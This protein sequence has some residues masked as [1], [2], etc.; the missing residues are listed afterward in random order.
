M[1]QNAQEVALRELERVAQPVVDAAQSF[2]K[3]QRLLLALGWDLDSVT[4]LPIA[5]IDAALNEV[6]EAVDVVLGLVPAADVGG[7]GI[8][9]LP[10]V[11][12]ALEQTA[13]AVQAVDSLVTSLDGAG[14][15]KPQGLDELPADLVDYL[16]C[17]FLQEY[18]ATLYALGALLTLVTP[19]EE[20]APPPSV[21]DTASGNVVRYPIPRPRLRLDHAPR[22]LADPLATLKAEYLQP[23]GLATTAG[24]DYTADKLFPRVAALLQTLGIAAVYGPKS[25]YRP[26]YGS[27]GNAVVERTLGVLSTIEVPAGLVQMGA[28]FALSPAD[29]GGL[30]LVVRPFGTLALGDE[31]GAWRVDFAV[32][33]SIR[34]FTIALDG[35]TFPSDQEPSLLIRLS[36]SKLQDEAGAAF[37]VGSATETR[38]E[39]GEFSI[40]T[41]GSFDATRQD[42]GFDV[43]IGSAALVVSPGNGD[44][45][46]QKVL[47]EEGLRTEFE[48]GIGWSKLKGLHFKGAAALEATLPVQADLLGVLKVN[49]VYLALKAAEERVT[50]A[51]GATVT[52]TLGPVTAVV[53]RMGLQADLSF[54]EAGGNLGLAQLDFDFKP[55]S[56][57]ALKVDAGVA[58]GGG[59]L[60]FDPRAEQYAGVLQ[61]ELG[62][63]VAVKAVGLLTTRMPDGSPGFSLLLIITAEGF[64]SIQL[65]FG[66]TLEGVG[67]L[68]GVNRTVYV[69]AL[70]GG[71]K[72]GVL[73]SILFPSDPARNAPALV[74]TIGAVMPP[75]SRRFLVGPMVLIGWG[76]PTI[77]TL[78]LA[79]LVELP[80]PVRLAILG[81]LA[82]QL[83]SVD[84]PVVR[85]QM[86]AIGIIDFERGEVSLDATLFDSRVLAF[87]LT[88]DMALRARWG[89]DPTFVLSV[90]GFNPRYPVPAGFPRL[91]RLALSLADSP[92]FR[93]RLAAY[94]ALT[95]NSVQFGARA[96]LYAGAGGFEIVG[97]VGFDALF[98]FS[99]FRFV[100]DFSAGIALKAGGAVIMSIQLEATLAGPTPW[101]VRGAARFEIL[102]FK[103]AV[104]IDQRFGPADPPP[105]PEAVDVESLV[106]AALADV[107]N[108]SS[109]LPASEHPLASLRDTRGEGLVVHPL[110]T[111][112]VRQRVAPLHRAISRFG[113]TVPRGASVFRVAVVAADARPLPPVE[114]VTDAF[115]RAHFDT[116]S[117]DQKLTLSAF[118]QMEAGFRIGS[119]AVDYP[120]AL[121]LTDAVQY[122][123]LTYDPV[124]TPGAVTNGAAPYALSS[125]VL[126]RVASLGAAAQSE[127]GRTGLDR[128]GSNGRPAAAAGVR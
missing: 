62:G 122:E 64:G 115:P 56:G 96:D 54:P 119:A 76:T 94:I 80:D 39:I 66:F 31:V 114:P 32:G 110:A 92:N 68:I 103:F 108:W 65:G 45:F 44:G 60:F 51:L 75:A 90:G 100:T 48:L 3:R 58:V 20:A 11:A 33:G 10:D 69:E 102:C 23:T 57:A 67:G 25:E 47:P 101:H 120:R 61:L 70:R 27:F 1:A 15:T 18:H 38:L 49:S 125:D 104:E 35:V 17:A 91:E 123:T 29:R 12:A 19:P 83:P 40:R 9:T 77:L 14:F 43:E 116:L 109:E 36:A 6:V 107:R 42:Y 5:R 24:A 59:Y 82:A 8:D 16:V 118:E 37:L 22:L 126:D 93:L 21:V 88:G 89:A 52:V 95:S 112:T 117:D 41:G 7:R 63:K 79:I 30:G 128:Y 28:A 106:R 81:R 85:L 98:E 121:A 34:G 87:V 99:P 111:V 46:L 97:H 13:Y 55:P 78:K 72:T 73:D 124:L 84:A 86:D 50:A 4:G 53:E 71:I 105:L 127:L 26:D 2:E 113:N 74:S